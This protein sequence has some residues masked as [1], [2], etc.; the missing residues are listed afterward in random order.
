MGKKQDSNFTNL[1]K[2]IRASILE[3]VVNSGSSHIGAAFSI[4]DILA[5]LY[6][7]ILKIN[8]A[9]PYWPNR[10]RFVLSKGHGGAAFY[11]VLGHRGFFP[12]ARLKHYSQNGSPMA[13]HIVKDSV[14]GMEITA[15]SLGHGLPIGL[16]MA[17]ALKRTKPGSKVFVLVGDGECNEGSVWEAATV[18][19]HFKLDNLIVIVDKNGQQSMG[20]SKEIMSMEPFAQKWRAFGWHCLECDGHNF[21]KLQAAFKKA[22]AYAGKPSVIVART[23]K[24]KGV[25]FMAKDPLTWHY[26][27][28]RD[29][30]LTQAKKELLGHA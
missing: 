18:A 29:N 25:S 1:T 19:A 11:A 2:Q 26:K 14:P 30:F 17:L 3:M 24:G 9:R 7:K 23:V 15:G 21:E 16:G 5:V 13:G 27:T 10:D 28:P 22:K 20:S 4:V 8:P 6:F 12:L